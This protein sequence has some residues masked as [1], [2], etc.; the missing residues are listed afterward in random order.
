M[1]GGTIKL[2][3]HNEATAHLY[4]TLELKDTSSYLAHILCGECEEV[5]RF[6][7]YYHF[8]NNK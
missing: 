6:E 5:A 7:Y 4:A 2:Y 3:E 8:D 1:E